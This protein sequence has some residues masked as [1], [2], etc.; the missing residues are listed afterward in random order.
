MTTKTQQIKS[1]EASMKELNA[2]LG[3]TKDH[4]RYLEYLKA[5]ELLERELHSLKTK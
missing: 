3:R 1:I 4:S 5:Y 2:R